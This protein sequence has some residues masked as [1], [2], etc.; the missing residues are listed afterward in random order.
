LGFV[1]GGVKVFRMRPP[2]L[3]YERA[4][5][6]GVLL[7]IAGGLGILAAKAWGAGLPGV[8]CGFRNV[9]GLPCAMCGGTRAASALMAG[10]WQGVLYWN[11]MAAVV[12]AGMVLAA[13]VCL[14]ELLRGR[15]LGDWKGLGMRLGRVVPVTLAVV[16][17]WWVAHV[18]MALG[19]P[20]LDLVDLRNPVAAAVAGW[21]GVR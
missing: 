9:S 17:V 1:G 12:L 8:P 21:L 19:T 7:A 15:A 18:V 5:R 11:A 4:M 3:G 20:K 13:G 14:V 2:L 10:D 6:W 16:A